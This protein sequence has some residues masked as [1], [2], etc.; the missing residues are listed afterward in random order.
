MARSATSVIQPLAR[1]AGAVLNIVLVVGA[2][3]FVALCAQVQVPLPFTPVPLTLASFGVLLVGLLLGPA[4]AGAA[5]LLY[6][7]EGAAGLPVFAP[8]GLPGIARF[9]GP[10][11]GYLLACPVAAFIAGRLALRFPSL[12]GRWM[13]AMSGIFVVFLGGTAQLALLT[14][15]VATAVALG[16]TPFALLDVAKAFVAALVAR[17]RE[18]TPEL[19]RR[20]ARDT[21][22]CWR[23]PA[24]ARASCPRARRPWAAA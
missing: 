20:R 17:P 15:S 5:M 6:L 8:G 9:W 7:A 10:T 22:S 13:A 23:H 21:A 12:V 18:R 2:S 24:R 19:R 16:A 14:G 1:P 3:L 11:G 4:R